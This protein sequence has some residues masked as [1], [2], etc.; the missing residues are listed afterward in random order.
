MRK[1]LRDIKIKM[2]ATDGQIDWANEALGMNIKKDS[3]N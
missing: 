3:E 2:I 1:E